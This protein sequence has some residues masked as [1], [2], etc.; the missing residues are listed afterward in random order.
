M[1]PKITNLEA[2][3]LTHHAVDKITGCWNYR[4]PNGGRKTNLKI[5]GVSVNPHQIV[6]MVYFGHT[7][8]GMGTCV[9]HRCDNHNCMNPGHLF[10]GSQSDNCLDRSNKGRGREN[11]QFG[12]ENANAKLNAAD[13]KDIIAA[14]KDGESQE[15]IARRYGVV[16]PHISRLV[17]GEQWQFSVGR[18]SLD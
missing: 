6:A 4:G 12:E 16:Q 5:D 9:C 1:P 8:N 2:W 14:W 15:S 10:L 17:R 13:I 3:I 18:V 7:P 11:R